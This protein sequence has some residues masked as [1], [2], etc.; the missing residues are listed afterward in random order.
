MATDS[1]LATPAPRLAAFWLTAAGYLLAGW[2]ALTLAIPPGYASPLYPAAGVAMAGVLLGG[3]RALPAVALGAFVVNLSI[4]PQRANLDLAALLL[5]GVIAAGAAAQAFVGAALV[6]RFTRQ[7]LTLSEPRDLAVFL[8]ATAVSCGVNASAA[9]TALW[10]TN[11][12]PVSDLAFSFATWWV[13]DV[14][15]V[16]IATPVVL[17]FLGHPREVWV[18]RRKSVG[19][20]LLLATTCWRSATSS[21]C[22]AMT[23]RWA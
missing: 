4:S 7:P 9:S 15:G 10:F 21:R 19:L 6:Q 5:P 12:V 14:L 22:A 16:L 11:T 1:H 2:A 23:P 8:V 13:G 17:S 3:W 18:P 20:T